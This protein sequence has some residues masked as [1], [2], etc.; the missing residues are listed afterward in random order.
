MKY[1]ELV[2]SQSFPEYGDYKART[3]RLVPGVY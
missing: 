2:L 1:E 3:A